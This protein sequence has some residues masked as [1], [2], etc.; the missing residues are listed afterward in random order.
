MLVL[1]Y[2]NIQM[3]DFSGLI[4]KANESLKEGVQKASLF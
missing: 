4:K 2:Q 3:I 1:F